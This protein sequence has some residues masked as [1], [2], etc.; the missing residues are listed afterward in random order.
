MSIHHKISKIQDIL[1]KVVLHY[2]TFPYNVNM[3]DI[4][5]AIYWAGLPQQ[6]N[7]RQ[8]IIA[9]IRKVLY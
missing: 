1:V 9:W 3:H 7:I 2:I 5:C 8:C 6:F 4:Q